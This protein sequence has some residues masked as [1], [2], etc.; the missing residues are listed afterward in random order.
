M[1]Y[2]WEHG[3]YD[4]IRAS[5]RPSPRYLLMVNPDVQNSAAPLWEH[6]ATNY[7]EQW[8]VLAQELANTSEVQNYRCCPINGPFLARISHR[9]DHHSDFGHD[10]EHKADGKGW[11]G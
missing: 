8:W 5:G 11:V 7:S 10:V 1:T 2:G 4:C 3:N 6:T 9:P